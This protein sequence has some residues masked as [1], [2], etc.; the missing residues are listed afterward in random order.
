MAFAQAVQS[1]ELV[2]GP[3]IRGAAKRFLEDL[4]KGA[5]RGLHW[6]LAAAQHALDFF[7][8]ILVLN[9]GAFEG[10]SFLLT[11]WQAFSVANLFGWKRASGRRRFQLAY[12][13]TAKGSGKSPFAAGVGLYGL[14]VDD[15]ERAEI[16]AAAT[17]RDQARVLFRDAVAMVKQSPVLRDRIRISGATGREYELFYGPR[18]SWFQL[19]SSDDGQSGPRPHIVLLDEIHEHKDATVVQMAE[20]GTKHRPNPITLMITNSGT[21]RSVVCREYHDMAV[22]A[23]TSIGDP[24]LDHV[25]SFVCGLDEQDDP[26]E[27]ESCWPKANPSLQHGIPGYD[28]LRKEIDSARNLPSKRAQVLRLNFCRWSDGTD[29]ALSL[30]AWSSAASHRREPGELYDRRCFA[31]IDLSSTTDLT[32]FV[33]LFEPTDDDPQWVIEPF[34]WL[35]EDTLREREDVDKVPYTVWQQQGLLRV[36]PGRTVRRHELMQD[37]AEIC[38][39][40]D[41]VLAGVDA[42]RMEDLQAMADAQG[43]SLPLLLKVRQGLQTMGPVVDELERQLLEESMVHPSHPVLTMCAANAVMESDAAGNRKFSKSRS[44]GRIDG[45]SALANAVAAMLSHGRDDEAPPS[46]NEVSDMIH[47]LIIV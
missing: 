24:A 5:Q 42:W 18:N 36:T 16:Y 29:Q 38:A 45:M 10:Q 17:K 46:V 21:H 27:D 28:Y 20:A 39:D 40:Y 32:A 37:I 35:P 26:F 33:L 44:R 9:G 15:E 3:F 22:R 23:V 12:I 13:E 1:G 31:G 34:F 8:E 41:V 19:L 47:G 43:L 2:A 6:D 7:E 30:T 14:L 25:F 4:G 11:P